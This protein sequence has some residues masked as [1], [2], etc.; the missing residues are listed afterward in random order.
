MTRRRVGARARA[1]LAAAALLLTSPVAAAAQPSTAPGR[2]GSPWGGGVAPWAPAAHPEGD[3]TVVAELLVVKRLP[4]P[5]M[6]KVSKGASQ[7]I[8]LGALVP[9]PHLL[10][11]DTN[12]IQHALNGAD[13]LLMDPRPKVGFF[14]AVGLLL[15]RGA[16]QLP[17]GQTLTRVLPPR[18]RARFLHAVQLI[19]KQPQDY[20][21]WKPAVAGFILIGD[22]RRAAG[23]SEGKPGTTVAKLAQADHVP[24]RYV[25]DFR[26]APYVKTVER[27]S[28]AQN[29]A[30]FDAAMDDIDQEANRGQAASKAWANAD[31]KTV[32]QAYS[33][34][35]FQRCL[36][37]A[38]GVQALVD[39]GTDLGVDEI[40]RELARPGK[41][42]AVIDLNFL[43]RR[44]GVL[45][46]L[47]ARGDAISVPQE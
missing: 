39:R 23:F 25:G 43:L 5:A 27:L 38:P 15:N 44:N 26:A 28:D 18:E 45:D 14:D 34:S 10:V 29:L 21:R 47:K 41:A 42:V 9:L 37:Q 11:W 40:D 13:V 8:V 32:R 20:W 12:P 19:H 3:S 46:R 22:F 31:L 33:V 17:H 7:V 2:G 4:G 24:I 30:C 6:W 36:V 16:L 35:T 1:I